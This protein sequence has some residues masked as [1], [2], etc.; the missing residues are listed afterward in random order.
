MLDAKKRI[1]ISSSK[2]LPFELTEK[3]KSARAKMCRTMP[4]GVKT[5]RKRSP[6]KAET[7]CEATVATQ[8]TEKRSI[9]GN[10]SLLINALFLHKIIH[11][12]ARLT[13]RVVLEEATVKVRAERIYS[14]FCIFA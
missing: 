4:I 10:V 5:R 14:I 12:Y 1:T 9:N 6:Q 7:A 8:S 2:A 13:L 11:A 3:R